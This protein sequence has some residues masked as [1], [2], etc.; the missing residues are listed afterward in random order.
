MAKI[1]RFQGRVDLL[2]R[3]AITMELPEFMLL[4]YECRLAEANEGAPDE[5]RVGM[6]HLMELQFAE[7]LTLAE[8]AL[9]ERK[10]PG[11]AAAVSRWLSEID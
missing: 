8:V 7:G 4:A 5:E 3:R 1:S 2:S 10:F 6:E 11:M 9:L